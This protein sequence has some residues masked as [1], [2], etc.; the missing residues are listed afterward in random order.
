MIGMT[1]RPSLS[2]NEEDRAGQ[3]FKLRDAGSYDAV[4]E[5]F[6]RWTEKFTKPF[7]TRLVDLGGVA[8]SETVLD[9]GTGTGIVAI[10][11]AEK[12]GESGKVLGID[13]SSGMIEA[14][15]AKADRLGLSHRLLFRRMDAEKLEFEDES[16]DVVVSLFALRHFPNPLTALREMH[17]VLRPGGRLV[18]AVGSGPP[19]VSLHGL[20]HGLRRVHEILLGLQG[21]R[22]VACKFLNTLVEKFLPE[23][24]EPEETSWVR[25]HPNLAGYVPNLVR[26]LGFTDACW[27]WTGQ[28]NVIDTA[29]E[30]WELQLTFSTFARKRVVNAPAG[31][32]KALRERFMVSCHKVQSQGG[33]LVYPTGAL[34]VC[35]QRD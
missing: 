23:S 9:V 35:G 13:L 34:F 33:K 18:V 21:R 30:F 4:T 6:D 2:V 16:F 12:V 1:G 31:R 22:L 27:K 10:Q 29:E 14:A 15:R 28:E 5:S 19:L 8:D 32:V 20:A 24:I 11:A 26:A 3:T 25:E 17:R 7:A